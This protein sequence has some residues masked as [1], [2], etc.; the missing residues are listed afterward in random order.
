MFFSIY[1]PYTISQRNAYNLFFRSLTSKLPLSLLPFRLAAPCS[2]HRCSS[3]FRFRFAYSFELLNAAFPR[4]TALLL[5]R[6]FSILSS[7]NLLSFLLTF[8]LF[9]ITASFFLPILQK[10]A[11]ILSIS[12]RFL[13]HDSLFSFC[14]N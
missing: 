8:C 3:A 1:S 6:T 2:L 4:A 14:F 10:N 12:G 11:P 5:Y 13:F 7:M 9:C